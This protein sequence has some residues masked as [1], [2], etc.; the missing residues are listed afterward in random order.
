M[1]KSAQVS[2]LLAIQHPMLQT[3]QPW[4]SNPEL[5]AAV[6]NAGDLGVLHPTA[7][8]DSDSDLVA[9]LKANIRRTHGLP[10]KPFAVALYLPSPQIE[11]LI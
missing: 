6:S 5:V 9:N 2:N 10:R 1:L 3:G 11:A 4:V 7:G 8:A